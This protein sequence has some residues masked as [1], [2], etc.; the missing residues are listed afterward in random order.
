MATDIAEMKQG[1]AVAERKP[2]AL[3]VP[4]ILEKMKPELMKALP[5]HMNADR[6]SRIA[7]TAFR[8]TPG[9]LKCDP[10]SFIACVV[11]CATLGLEPNT[12]TGEAYLI[13]FGANCTTVIGYQGLIKLAKQ[14]GQVVDIY[15]MEVR[16][17]DHFRCEFG[18]NRKLIHEPK[19]GRAGFPA[20]DDERG[21]V[22]GY[23]AVAVFRDGS[24]TFVAMTQ[25]DVWKVRDASQGWQSAK[26]YGREA[27]S[28]WST[29]A[30]EMGKKTVIRRVCKLL[31]KSPELQG[32]LT[33]EDARETGR[34]AIIADA[35]GV[36]IPQMLYDAPV[37]PDGF[38]AE[39]A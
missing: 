25:E 21:E 29:D 9:L 17:H 22:V 34:A 24:R 26:K 20:P 31:P 27:K 4:A 37:D 11:Q 2:Q 38:E 6:M 7:L 19:E 23:Y 18:L 30:V 14:T 3:T 16:E 8:T 32:A 12:G 36:I 35:D 28:P 15:A 39:A 10:K 1:S 5:R 33:L 13:P